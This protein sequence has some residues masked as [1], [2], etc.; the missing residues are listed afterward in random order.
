MPALPR[1]FLEKIAEDHKLSEFEREVFVAKFTDPAKTDIVVSKEINISRDR[2]SSRMSGVYKKFRISG[3]GPGKSQI[4]VF[5]LLELYQKL[6]ASD[7]LSVAADVV[8]KAVK[9]IKP[10]IE[11]IIQAHCGSMRVLDMNYPVEVKEIYTELKI[12]DRVNA[13]RHMSISELMQTFDPCSDEFNSIGLGTSTGQRI[14]GIDLIRREPKLMILGRPGAGKT[15][16]LKYV[17]VSCVQDRFFQEYVPVFVSL[18]DFSEKAEYSSLIDYI[19]NELSHFSVEP[20]EVYKLLD[21]A[22]VIFLLD[23]LDEVKESYSRHVLNEIRQLSQKFY[24]NRF[25]VTCR[26]AAQEYVF[27]GFTEVEIADFNQEQMRAFADNWFSIK[28]DSLKAERI[29]SHLESNRRFRELATNPLLLTLLCLVFEDSGDFPSNRSELYQEGLDVLLKKWDAGRNI[30][31]AQAYQKMSRQRKEDLLSN[32]AFA[33]FEHN[34]YFFKRRYIEGEIRNY[35]RNLPESL[36]NT[37]DLDPDCQAILKSIE[38]QHGLIVERARGIYSFSHLTFHEFFASRQIA[39]SSDPRSQQERL[40]VLVSHITEKRWREVFL[41]V[42]GMLPNADYLLTL[43]KSKIDSLLIEEANIQRFLTWVCQKALSV[44]EQSQLSFKDSRVRGFYFDLAVLGPGHQGINHE[45]SFDLMLD[46]QLSLALHTSLELRHDLE[47]T[48]AV[49]SVKGF[50]A[51]LAQVQESHGVID[52]ALRDCMAELRESPFKADLSGIQS[53]LPKPEEGLHD[54]WQSKGHVWIDELI[55][56]MVRH[57]N[58]GHDWRFSAD[59]LTRLHQY[60]EANKLLLECVNSDCY[61]SREVRDRILQNMF[62]PSRRLT[63]PA[64]QSPLAG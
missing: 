51:A 4:L 30:E 26:L 38:S 44:S 62:L 56:V 49:L 6:N 39:T 35:I 15:T 54:W 10:K 42:V 33:T 17:A 22:R 28:K 24:K 63:K 25:L 11:P 64:R 21:Y 12:L 58:L 31:R 40:L 20:E 5:R 37:Q 16:F 48:N 55:Q 52:S 19:V 9:R 53:Q 45:D 57:R 27:E 8:N 14:S 61:V 43:M 3:N 50:R 46:A 7:Y 41:L 13:N 18:R 23:G 59:E 2:F 60:Y 1:P 32:I 36:I 34:D 29:V 47:L